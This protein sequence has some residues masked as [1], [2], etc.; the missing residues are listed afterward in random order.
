MRANAELS[1]DVL[2]CFLF[3]L[4]LDGSPLSSAFNVMDFSFFRRAQ[5]LLALLR[6]ISAVRLFY[7][8]RL[9]C[10]SRLIVR[11]STLRLDGPRWLCAF[12]LVLYLMPLLHGYVV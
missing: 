7:R 3:A 12:G 9:H 10:K 8:S 6:C 4:W 11:R 1:A 2:M 5:F